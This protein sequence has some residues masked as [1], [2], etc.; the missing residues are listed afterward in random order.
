[1]RAQTLSGLAHLPA[2]G[3][4]RFEQLGLHGGGEPY[5]EAALCPA[6]LRDEELVEAGVVEDPEDVAGASLVE[7]VAQGLAVGESADDAGRRGASFLGDGVPEL[8]CFSV[9]VGGSAD[10][11][12]ERCEPAADLDHDAGVAGEE[13]VCVCFRADS[14]A[15]G[16]LTEGCV[17]V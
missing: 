12:V 16:L 5:A 1:M 6:A 9:G 11:F 3:L 7:I 10:C 14:A 13:L 8:A 17:R 4:E 2:A 15:A